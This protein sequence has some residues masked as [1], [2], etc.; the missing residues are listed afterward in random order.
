MIKMVEKIAYRDGF[1]DVLAEGVKR[2]AEK[3]GKD[4]WKWAME[5]KGLEQSG[6]DTRVAKGYAL[7]FAV[8]PRGVD[9]LHT[10]TFA[11]LGLSKEGRQLIKEI[12]KSYKFIEPT[13]TEKKA[14]IVRWHEDCYAITDALGFCAFTTTALYGLTPK[15]MAEMWSAAIGEEVS[16]EELMK[17]GRRIVTLEK[18]Y[19][20]RCGATRSDDRLPWR[21]MN[22]D[23]EDRPGENFMA[24]TQ[25]ELDKMLDEYYGLHGWDLK[26]SRPTRKVFEK[27]DLDFVIE[28]FEKKN[29]L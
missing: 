7:A 11:E 4:S 1:G 20:I 29:K 21:I 12:T 5:G 8:N 22:E 26:S 24:N 27:L 6:V 16:E 23:A 19:N 13:S 9:H 28:E 2:A 3:V 25:K 15:M 17:A 18:A 10:E 14:E